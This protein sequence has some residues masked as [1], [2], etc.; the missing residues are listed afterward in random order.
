MGNRA[1]NW[2]KLLDDAQAALDR[3]SLYDRE[4]DAV[5]GILLRGQLA[6][7]QRESGMKGIVIM[8]S[9]AQRYLRFLIRK[10]NERDPI[11]RVYDSDGNIMVQDHLS[12]FKLNETSMDGQWAQLVRMS[13]HEEAEVRE[14]SFEIGMALINGDTFDAWMDM[15][16]AAYNCTNLEHMAMIL[17]VTPSALE[18]RCKSRKITKGLLKRTLNAI[19]GVW[20]LHHRGNW[21]LDRFGYGQQRYIKMEYNNQLVGFWT[22]TDKVTDKSCFLIRRCSRIR[23][24]ETDRNVWNGKSYPNAMTISRPTLKVL[25]YWLAATLRPVPFEDLTTKT[26]Q[27]K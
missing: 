25:P 6:L 11:K 13:Q 24:P 19:P 15:Q 20:V 26:E 18:K 17:D 9:N 21:R 23:E 8:S 7:S 4:R 14:Q 5:K 16:M 12:P 27:E 2:R 3:D 1:I 10:A 22:S